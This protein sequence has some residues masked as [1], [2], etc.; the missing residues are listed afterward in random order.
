MLRPS[1]GQQQQRG[2][3]SS[4]SFGMG[5]G[6][7][8]LPLICP[9]CMGGGANGSG[10][11]C[12]IPHQRKRGAGVFMVPFSSLLSV[13]MGWGGMAWDGMSRQDAPIVP[14]SACMGVQLDPPP[15]AAASC[16]LH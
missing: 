15:V 14:A 2:G 4:E 3:G 6:M 11:S 13:R 5:V 7:L 16:Q 8:C 9:C 10:C 1:H 12:G